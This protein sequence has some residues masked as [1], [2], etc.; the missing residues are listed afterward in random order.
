MTGSDPAPDGQD[1]RAQA[2]DLAFRTALD[3]LARGD[4]GALDRTFTDLGLKKPVLVLEPATKALPDA[5][6]RTVHAHWLALR[7]DRDM[8]DWP[9]FSIEGLGVDA[10]HLAVVDPVPGTSDF[11]FEVY[12]SSV[13]GAARRDYRGETVREMGLRVGT[14]GPLLYRAVYALVKQRRVPAYTWNVAPPW[15]K[16]EAWNRLVLPF[17][18]DGD[19]RFLV[20]LK[21][22]GTRA[23]SDAAAYEGE[24]RL[25]FNPTVPR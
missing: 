7:G 20:C 16:V 21:G 13:I 25:A 1:A 18:L 4:S 19:I 12:G 9:D 24:K 5:T 15:Q 23:V 11:R 8:P 10:V 14:P 22:D 6:L 3:G 17:A 2:Y